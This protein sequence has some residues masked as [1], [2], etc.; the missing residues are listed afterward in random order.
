M[1][2]TGIY[3]NFPKEHASVEYK[4]SSYIG[5]IKPETFFSRKPVQ[6]KTIQY[7]R[8]INPILTD[9]KDKYRAYRYD[10]L[11]N[12]CN[13]FSNEF[14]GELFNGTLTIPNWVNRAAWWGS[15]FHC[16]VPPQL[17]TV[18]PEG[19]DTAECLL[20]VALWK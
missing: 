20:K 7:S 2:T 4:C 13:H 1:R 12:N 16:C 10:M 9:L 6:H 17:R 8:D 18:T 15:W 5:E 14:I 19:Y 3:E 11:L